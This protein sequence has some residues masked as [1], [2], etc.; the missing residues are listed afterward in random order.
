[1]KSAIVSCFPGC[2]KTHL[3]LNNTSSF[4]IL[5]LESTPFSTQN[6][7]PENYINTI[8]SKCGNY[9]IILISQHEEVLQLLQEKKYTF[10]VVSPNNSD[11]LSPKKRALIKQ[12]WFGRFFLRDNKHIINS[13]GFDEWLKIITEN[14]EEWT[15][16]EHLAKYSPSKI[17]LLDDG[18]YISDIVQKIY[19]DVRSL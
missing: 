9:D 2:G 8:I 7:W 19:N 15:S 1:M 14:Y 11:Y 18:E 17:Y 6:G 10:F 16:I 4:K 12:Q 3:H 13:I 5:D